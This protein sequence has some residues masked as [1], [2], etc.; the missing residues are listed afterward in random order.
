MAASTGRDAV[1]V[2]EAFEE[3]T[4]WLAAAGVGGLLRAG[5]G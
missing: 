1:N 5:C 4:S 2:V 3:K